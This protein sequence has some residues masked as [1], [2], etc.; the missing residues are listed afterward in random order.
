MKCDGDHHGHPRRHANLDGGNAKRSSHGQIASM[1][2]MLSRRPRTKGAKPRRPFILYCRHA[3]AHD[4]PALRVGVRWQVR[5]TPDFAWRQMFEAAVA[6]DLAPAARPR[7]PWRRPSMQRAIV[8]QDAVCCTASRS[9]YCTI[10]SSTISR[11]MAAC[12]FSAQ[13]ARWFGLAE[14]GLQTAADRHPSG[15][16][17]AP[18]SKGMPGRAPH[19]HGIDMLP[20]PNDVGPG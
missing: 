10:C 13:Q 1:M 4:S 16:P 17:T 11:L 8:Y 7:R 14:S 20:M 15:R 19:H 12:V 3:A 18:A 9:M 2:A 5:Q 6:P